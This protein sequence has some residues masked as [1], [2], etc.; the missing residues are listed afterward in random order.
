MK[1]EVELKTDIEVEFTDPDKVLKYFI[2]D[3]SEG[4]WKNYFFKF[5]DIKEL[6]EHLSEVIV[7]IPERWNQEGRCFSRDMEGFALFNRDY[8]RL[9]STSEEYG[10]I[11]IRGDEDDTYIDWCNEVNK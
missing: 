7:K 1:F 9:V 4:A 6:A 11:I 10:S 8:G 3:T 2:E 5:D